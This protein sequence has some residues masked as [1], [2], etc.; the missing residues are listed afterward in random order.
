MGVADRDWFREG[1]AE[2]RRRAESGGATWPGPPPSDLP[3]APRAP[4]QAPTRRRPRVG[5][6]AVVALLV[7]AGA[8]AAALAA[9]EAWRRHPALAADAAQ[10]A[11]RVRAAVA[12]APQPQ[13][14]PGHGHAEWAVGVGE[15]F[16]G[17]PLLPLRINTFQRLAGPASG[18]G[19]RWA[20]SIRPWAGGA[21]LVRL[22]LDGGRAAVVMLPPGEYQVV[23]ARGSGPWRGPDG[24]FGPGTGVVRWERPLRL[25]F[26]GGGGGRE[27]W[28]FGDPEGA[29]P[30]SPAPRSAM[31]PPPPGR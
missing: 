6:A 2:R 3:P 20:V 5:I 7:G 16:A 23:Y 10:L 24:L 18:A 4:R 11:A 9:S 25:G 27:A 1:A 17:L 30:T 29:V 28:L 22:H 31:A 21:E 15:R 8:V 14:W 19:D 13:P 26:D 12:P